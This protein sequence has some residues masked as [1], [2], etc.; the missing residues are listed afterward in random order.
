MNALV[1]RPVAE[2]KI[3]LGRV[4]I[5]KSRG[6]L[7]VAAA[8][9]KTVA[10]IVRCVE[11]MTVGQLNPLFALAGRGFGRERD[12]QKQYNKSSRDHSEIV[13]QA[14]RLPNQKGRRSARPTI[15]RGDDYSRI[16]ERGS[17]R[18]WQDREPNAC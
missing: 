6:N 10:I 18:K 1:V 4:D 3:G 17:R 11:V 9:P 8:D 13:G 16:K 12:Q 2:S 14:H 7:F 5:I 15:L